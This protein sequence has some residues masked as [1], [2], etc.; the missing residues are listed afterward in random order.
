[1]YKILENSERLT[2]DEIMEKYEGN[3]VYIVDTHGPL[4]GWFETGIVAVVGDDPFEDYQTGIY[5]NFEAKYNGRVI[6]WAINLPS[7]INV[8]G[9]REEVPIENL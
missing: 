7:E 1:M 9:F 4:F 5:R 8:F 2:A 6:G 3:W